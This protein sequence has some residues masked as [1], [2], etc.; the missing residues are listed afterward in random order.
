LAFVEGIYPAHLPVLTQTSFIIRSRTKTVFRASNAECRVV[1]SPSI[2]GGAD[3][4]R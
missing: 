2:D 3:A 1:A 4:T